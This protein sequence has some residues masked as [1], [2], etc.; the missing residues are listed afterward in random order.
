MAPTNRANLRL[1]GVNANVVTL[2]CKWSIRISRSR[3]SYLHSWRSPYALMTGRL[4]DLRVKS[5][6]R[7]YS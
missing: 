5:W 1:Y 4:F 2:K 6:R 7:S 3:S